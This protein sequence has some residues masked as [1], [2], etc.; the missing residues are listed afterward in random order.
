M[1]DKLP[2]E[3]SRRVQELVR[4]ECDVCG[5]P[6]THRITYLVAVNCRSNPASAAFGRDNCSWCSD[7]ESYA[8]KEH[9]K[10]IERD[11]PHGMSWCTT[12]DAVGRYDHMLLRWQEVPS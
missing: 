11:A 7:A 10:Q 4:R 2:A 3:G 5:E 9:V 1:S 6:A 12:F 8:C